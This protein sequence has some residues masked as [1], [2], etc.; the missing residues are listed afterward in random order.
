[1]GLN[2]DISRSHHPERIS[3]LCG[4]LALLFP[5][6][7]FT[8]ALLAQNLIAA[9][10]LVVHLATASRHC[11]IWLLF[12]S[13]IQLLLVVSLGRMMKRPGMLNIWIKSELQSFGVW[14]RSHFFFLVMN[15]TCSVILI[16]VSVLLCI[17]IRR[18][19]IRPLCN[20]NCS[21]R[22]FSVFFHTVFTLFTALI[23]PSDEFFILLLVH[24]LCIVPFLLTGF[25]QSRVRFPELVCKSCSVL[26]LLL[27]VASLAAQSPLEQEILLQITKI[28]CPINSWNVL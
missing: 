14:G 12:C 3:L 26:S 16:F 11:C 2:N 5:H 23:Y 17:I 4:V 15:I 24:F 13:S 1:M 25:S 8:A 20:T 19:S 7:L 18:Y 22:C 9:C 27:L 28:D 10:L 21:F 6:L